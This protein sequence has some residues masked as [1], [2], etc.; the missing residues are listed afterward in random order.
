MLEVVGVARAS[1]PEGLARLQE[2]EGAAEPLGPPIHGKLR[3]VEHAHTLK[4]G[5][6]GVLLSRHLPLPWEWR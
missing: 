6:H 4:I 3:Q 5:Y 2:V 1:H